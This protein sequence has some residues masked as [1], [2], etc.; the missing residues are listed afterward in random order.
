MGIKTRMV[1][2]ENEN[3]DE[4]NNGMNKGNNEDDHKKITQRGR[5]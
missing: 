2:L 3:E 5:G 1:I 4:D